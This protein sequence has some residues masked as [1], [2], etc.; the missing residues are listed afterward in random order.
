MLSCLCASGAPQGAAFP[1][2]SF[3][4]PQSRRR[5]A[6]LAR[7]RADLR[8]SAT[9]FG[10]GTTVGEEHEAELAH[11]DLI[12]AAERRF[13]DPFPVDVRTVQAAHVADGEAIPVP[14]KLGVPP[15]NGHVIEEDVALRMTAGRGQF[16]VEQEPAAGVRPA[17]DNE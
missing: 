1:G 8:A 17:L 16:T 3:L 11:L 14:V 5:R 2:R 4:A 7:S 9:A 10:L 12:P 15:G 6:P 13:L